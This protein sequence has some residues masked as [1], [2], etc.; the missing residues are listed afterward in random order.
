MTGSVATPASPPAGA[1]GEVSGRE[2]AAGEVAVLSRRAVGAG[3]AAP[4]GHLWDGDRVAGLEPGGDLHLRAGADP[5][6][7]GGLD[8]L[9]TDDLVDVGPAGRAVQRQLRDDEDV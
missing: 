8:G 3:G 2:V 5:G 4:G 9:A 7:D 6:R 1:A